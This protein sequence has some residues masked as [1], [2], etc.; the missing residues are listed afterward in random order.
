MYN[1]DYCEE[2]SVDSGI[3]LCWGEEMLK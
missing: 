3:M 2:C 1:E